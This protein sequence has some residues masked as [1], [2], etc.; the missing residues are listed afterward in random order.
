M[1]ETSLECTSDDC[2]YQDNYDRIEER[3]STYYNAS[4]LT[5]N[6]YCDVCHDNLGERELADIADWELEFL[7]PAMQKAIKKRLSSF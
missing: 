2:W 5:T 7:V 1:E 4:E 6:Y 3:D